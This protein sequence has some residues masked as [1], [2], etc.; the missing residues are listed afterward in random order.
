MP[1]FHIENYGC[2][3]NVSEASSLRALLIEHGHV[4]AE[5]PAEADA[6]ILN[7][8]SVRATAEQRI[9]GRIG[10]YKGLN[11][12]N[13]TD[14]KV[15]VMGCMAQH[16]GM[17]LRE[18]FPGTVEAVWGTYH[19]EGVLHC[20]DHLGDGHENS[21][22]LEGY[23]FLEARPQEK[24]PFKSFVPI[25]HG[26]DNFCSYCIVPHVRGREIGRNAD[27]IIGNIH[28]LVSEGVMEV[29][30]LGQNVN[31]YR[32]ESSGKAVLF[33]EL[34]DRVAKTADIPRLGFMTS[35]PKDF[36][37]ELVTVM[38]DNQN[39][40]RQIHLP[41]QAGSDRILELMN[42]KYTAAQYLEKVE[43]AKREITGIVLSTDIIVG[44]PGETEQEF[45]QTLDMMK[46]VEYHEAYTYYYNRR[47]GTRAAEMKDDVPVSVKKERLAELI[48]LQK[49]ISA[50]KMK[51]TVGKELSVLVETVS[52]KSGREVLGRADNTLMTYLEG[53]AG[54]VGKIVKVK[55]TGA[56]IS[57]LKGKRV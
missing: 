56:G 43:M 24:F 45:L 57:G 6:V 26:C 34:L 36:S 22:D 33:P 29:I 28:K 8:C 47:P 2:Q 11:H 9:R 14:I 46:K 20:L 25:S 51:E 32:D 37:L 39:I 42:R 3:M 30:L 13:G 53:D 27:E 5:N 12:V 23:R 16:Y 21:L 48:R 52:K 19:K 49:E 15:I 18:D 7:T 10:Y 44:F 40:L 50:R 54:L 41:L 31:S 55:I 38:R 17:K 1:K 35:H 4:E